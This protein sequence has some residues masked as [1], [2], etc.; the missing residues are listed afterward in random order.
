VEGNVHANKIYS[1]LLVDDSED[2]RFFLRNAISKSSCFKLLHEL[3]DGEEAVKYLAG[4]E[5]F[6]KREIYPLPDLLVLDLKMPRMNGYEVLLWLQSHPL[7]SMT[8]VVLSGSVL[9]EDLEV[10]LDLGA[11]GFWSKT[12]AAHKQRVMLHEMEALVHKR[13][14]T[15]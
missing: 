3:C 8:I 2:D 15:A 12:S 9:H 7:P 13:L 10:S 6:A 5:H 11:H 4:K 1:V 14:T